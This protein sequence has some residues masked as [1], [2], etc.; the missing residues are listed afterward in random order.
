M[1][2]SNTGKLKEDSE[3]VFPHH[4]LIQKPDIDS[5]KTTIL[6][7]TFTPQYAN[8]YRMN[9]YYFILPSIVYSITLVFK[10]FYYCG[11]NYFKQ[12]IFSLCI[13]SRSYWIFWFTNIN[14]TWK[15]C[16]N[17]GNHLHNIFYA[18]DWKQFFY[19]FWVES[20]S[21]CS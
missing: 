12:Q 18:L 7:F 16:S 8:Q 13:S 15:I 6:F 11:S 3:G 2:I 14:F 5:F 9:V 20:N 10:M 1:Y 4:L 21:Q 19:A 17:I